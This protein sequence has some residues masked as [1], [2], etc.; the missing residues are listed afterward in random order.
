M[1]V[2][3]ALGDRMLL[4]QH[5]KRPAFEGA[6]GSAEATFP[7]WDVTDERKQG[8]MLDSDR[9]SVE[10]HLARELLNYFTGQHPTGVKYEDQPQEVRERSSKTFRL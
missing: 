10:E 6:I 8:R 7:K 5:A 1:P 2:M 9:R 4:D 3:L